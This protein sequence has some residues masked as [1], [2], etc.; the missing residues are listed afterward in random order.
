MGK[1]SENKGKLF[2]CYS[3]DCEF[4]IWSKVSPNIWMLL[5]D[6]GQPSGV[7]DELG[8]RC[9]CM[10]KYKSTPPIDELSRMLEHCAGIIEQKD[11]ETST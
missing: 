7:K 9:I 5:Q 8:S 11:V 3:S 1:K 4:F 6:E 2:I 10:G